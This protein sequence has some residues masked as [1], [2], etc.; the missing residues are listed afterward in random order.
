L[1]ETIYRYA[2]ISHHGSRSAFGSGLARSR[3][4]VIEHGVN[5]CFLSGSGLKTLKSSESAT[6][7]FTP[8]AK[9]ARSP[10]VATENAGMHASQPSGKLRVTTLLARP[11][12]SR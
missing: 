2:R 4:D 8:R 12:L 1:E 5:Q 9:H 6:P 11:F 7:T 3:D 10:L